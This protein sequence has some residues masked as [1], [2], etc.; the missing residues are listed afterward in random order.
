M[1]VVEQSQLSDKRELFGFVLFT[2]G[3]VADSFDGAECIRRRLDM[4]GGL[5]WFAVVCN[6]DC[7]T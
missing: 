4:L 6:V 2:D 7:G 5:C 1:L 3:G